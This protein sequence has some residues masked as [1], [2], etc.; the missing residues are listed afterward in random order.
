MII[1]SVSDITVKEIKVGCSQ[2]IS[3]ETGKIIN[4]SGNGESDISVYKSHAA[5]RAIP[6]YLFTF[7]EVSGK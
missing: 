1:A 6:K 4:V 3:N 5:K 7:D 2:K